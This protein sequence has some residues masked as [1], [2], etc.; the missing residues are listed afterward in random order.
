MEALS[1]NERYTFATTLLWFLIQ[2]LFWGFAEWS[3]RNGPRDNWW[4]F[5]NRV[6]FSAYDITEFIF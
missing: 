2:V 4:P 1:K 6:G 5:S 3:T